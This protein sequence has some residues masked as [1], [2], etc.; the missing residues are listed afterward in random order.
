MFTYNM[1]DSEH[2]VEGVAGG[3]RFEAVYD[4]SSDGH[5]LGKVIQRA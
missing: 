4:S 3:A 1:T 2:H 5:E